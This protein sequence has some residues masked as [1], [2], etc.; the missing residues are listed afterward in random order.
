MANTTP[1]AVAFANGRARPLADLLISA[2]LSSKAFAQQWT[3]QGVASVIPNDATLIA[4]GSATDGRTPITDGDINILLAQAQSII[5]LF[6]G[7]TGAPA[8][9]ASLQNF[10]Q[11][12][13]ISVNGRAI[14]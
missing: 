5:A 8:N 14:F 12:D 1:Q 13:K 3:A 10:N 9:N 6:E 11:I 4:D 2:Y 7:A